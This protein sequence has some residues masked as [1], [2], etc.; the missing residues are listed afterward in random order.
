MINKIDV[1]NC[2][3]EDLPLKNNDVVLIAKTKN[4]YKRIPFFIQYYRMIGIKYF[5]FI[6]NNSSD[7]TYEFLL[8]Q[9]N[10]KVFFTTD[11]LP[12]HHL[13]I[14]KILD[15]FCINRWSL[16]VDLDELFCF[17]N[18]E[19]VKINRIIEY[20]DLKGYDAVSSILLDMYPRGFLSKAVV[21][22]EYSPLS[23]LQFFDKN[24]H[25][26]KYN[27]HY[28]GVRKRIFDVEP[29]LTKFPLIKHN[30]NIIIGPGM[31]SVKNITPAKF[32][33]ALLHCKFDSNF[34][35]KT[36]QAVESAVYW[37]NSEEYKKYAEKYK[38]KEELASQ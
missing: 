29:C 20:L 18:I 11:A 38:Y 32:S 16:I 5:I 23:L 30:P 33:T 3:S 6:D 7:D 24:S 19:S 25:F 37:N 4:E 17:S 10:T 28:G 14:K 8:K 35:T 26:L 2:S 31:H 13:W 12:N 21:K 1:Y 27:K 34:K 15:T 22:D 36:E 9:G